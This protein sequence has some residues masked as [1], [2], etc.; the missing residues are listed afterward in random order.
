MNA[1]KADVAHYL[2]AAGLEAVNIW[3]GSIDVQPDSLTRDK[4]NDGKWFAEFD[5][6]AAATAAMSLKGYSGLCHI[7]GKMVSD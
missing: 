4:N 3:H 7:T 5:N 1:I 2:G 6:A